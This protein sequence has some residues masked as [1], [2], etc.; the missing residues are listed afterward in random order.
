MSYALY[1]T[2]FVIFIIGIGL[3]AH[4]L[5]VPARWITV[6]VLIFAGLGVA[7]GVSR[8]RNRDPS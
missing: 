7:R 3:G 5:H 8:T 4:Y 6:V 2:G 1:V